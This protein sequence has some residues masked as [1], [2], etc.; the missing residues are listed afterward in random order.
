MLNPIWLILSNVKGL[1]NKT[2]I[3]LYRECP[4]LSI[5]NYFSYEL[6]I[7]RIIKRESILKVILNPEFLEREFMNSK[8]F[9][10]SHK[11]KNIDLIDIS[12]EYYPKLLKSIE[13]PPIII[14]TKGNI[15]LLKESRCVAFIGTRE[16][17]QKGILA[18]KKIAR[19]FANNNFIIVSG[20]ATGIDTAGHEGALEA[21]GGKTI[22]VMA[23]GLDSIYP[24]ENKNLAN[25]ILENKGL[26]ISE[27]PMGQRPFKSS[28]VQR[29]RIQSGLSLAICPVQ[30]PI[31]S[32]TQ[33]TIK[34]ALNQNRV[35]FCP[36]PQESESIKATQGVYQLIELK[37][38]LVIKGPEDY[39]KIINAIKEVANRFKVDFSEEFV[40]YNQNPIP[41]L[42]DK[43]LDEIIRLCK[44]Y[45]ISKETLINTIQKKFF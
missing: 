14:Y 24:A 21:K 38:A 19:L 41:D 42:V 31:E 27:Y 9:I 30:T 35:L 7:I 11:D 37:K 34:F 45:Q 39:K 12:S 23:G 2:L 10:N 29:D 33:H 26:L 36:Y 20:L 28:F 22:A 16:P 3:N 18:A 15:E 5:D 17:T 44:E 4:T 8:A 13:D 25:G 32:G 43:E 1:G 40:N 6:E